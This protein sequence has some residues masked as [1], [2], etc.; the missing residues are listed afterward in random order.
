MGAASPCY[1]PKWL[2]NGCNRMGKYIARCSRAT[3]LP[4]CCTI[5]IHSAVAERHEEAVPMHLWARER[6]RE[7][8]LTGQFYITLELVDKKGLHCI[9][10]CV[11]DRWS[12]LWAKFCPLTLGY[13]VHCRFGGGGES[14][15]VYWKYPRTSMMLRR[16]L[17]RLILNVP[18]FPHAGSYVGVLPIWMRMK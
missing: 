5:L 2:W 18:L 7:G 15:S 10:H 4:H 8:N 17:I 16:V 14:Y 9:Q 1:R 12:S 6:E 11:G 13:R 3:G